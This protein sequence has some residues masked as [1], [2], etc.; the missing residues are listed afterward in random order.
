MLK[1]GVS[2]VVIKPGTAFLPM[3]IKSLN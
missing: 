3:L 1:G 2:G